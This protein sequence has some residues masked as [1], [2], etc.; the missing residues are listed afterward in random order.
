MKSI[1]FK[2]TLNFVFLI[3]IVSILSSCAKSVPEVDN[4]S[5]VGWA[6]GVMENNAGTIL[7][8]FNNGLD[9]DK[10]HTTLAE[11]VDLFGVSAISEKE[12][13][14]VGGKKDGFGMILRTTDGG[15]TWQRVGDKNMIPNF[16]VFGIQA[17]TDLKLW[18]CGDSGTVMKTMNGGGVWTKMPVD[19][20]SG[21]N[22]RFYS[23]TTSG[24]DNIWVIG[25]ES[26]SSGS[27]AV[28]IHSS[29]GGA[30][31][32]RQGQAFG[33]SSHLSDIQAI[34]D[35]TV[36]VSGWEHIY[37]THDG[38]VTWSTLLTTYA[39]DIEGICVTDENT[40]WAAASNNSIYHS[41]DM[42]A[43]WDTIHSPYPNTSF[44]G[45]TGID[46]L[47]V[48]ATGVSVSGTSQSMLLYTQNAGKTWFYG[49]NESRGR[50]NR[51]SFP[52]AVK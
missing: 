42:G 13:W 44:Y 25:T 26:G 28:I 37:L 48:W 38:G 46:N 12:V 22:T 32:E 30:T 51:V 5:H 45:I 15:V 35:L 1:V 11:G 17:V 20:L 29:N 43:T 21:T 40:V 24:E 4:F 49:E 19:T 8:T 9:W 34:D 18:V 33:I 23:I 2:R 39:N 6:V 7:H 41:N 47:H 52:A 10:Q 36:F 16:S 3:V 14:V 31:W 50:I 27:Q